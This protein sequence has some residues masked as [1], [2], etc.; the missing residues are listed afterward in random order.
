MPVSIE[1][2]LLSAS[3]RVDSD[4]EGAL[5]RLIESPEYIVYR[6]GEI[7][8]E[9]RTSKK[10]PDIILERGAATK[11]AVLEG[12]TLRLT[13]EWHDGEF[14]RIMIAMLTR[15]LEKRGLHPLHASA[16]HYRGRTFVMMS[17]EENHGK[18]MT[19]IESVI[20]G[21]EIVGAETIILDDEGVIVGVTT[22][23]F[24]EGRQKGTERVDKPPARG[25]VLKFFKGYLPV[26]R[27]KPP[28][29]RPDLVILPD[30]DGNYD[31]SVAE[32]ALFEKEYQSFHSLSN[33]YSLPSIVSSGIEMPIL[34]T[35]GLR[36]RRASYAMALASKYPFFFIRG[37]DPQSIL[38][39][40]ERILSQLR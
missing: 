38:D 17:G 4:D 21:G 30:I 3:V 6:L 1:A 2:S 25:G 36:R 11:D 9:K 13:G 33:Y 16:V 8:I 40:V 20:R 5:M 29:I 23:V 12:D 18:T 7:R 37:P 39:E 34:E 35:P 14:Q 15:E 32:M 27:Y 28:P 10:R 24:L 26:F 19:L 31:V 22:G